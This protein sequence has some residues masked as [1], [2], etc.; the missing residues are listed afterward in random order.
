M[1]NYPLASS[2][3]QPCTD[4]EPGTDVGLRP[5]QPFTR[6]KEKFDT[7]FPLLYTLLSEKG[8]FIIKKRG[9]KWKG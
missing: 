5:T 2:N 6:G 9:Q 1:W 3:K 8:I 7:P 4:K